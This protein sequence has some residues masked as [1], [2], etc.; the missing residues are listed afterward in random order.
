MPMP[1]SMILAGWFG[2]KF[3]RLYLNN[4]RRRK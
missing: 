3:N 1:A 2:D 4:V